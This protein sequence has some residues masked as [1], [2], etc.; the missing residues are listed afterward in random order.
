MKYHK[1]LREKVKDMDSLY[2]LE[3]RWPMK[4]YN[5]IQLERTLDEAYYPGLSEEVLK[6]LNTD[7]VVM[8]ALSIKSDNQKSDSEIPILT[9]PQ[10]WLWRLDHV[11]VSAYASA[12]QLGQ[13]EFYNATESPVIPFADLHIGH[14]LAHHVKAFNCAY[15]DGP[16]HFEP[17]LNIFETAMMQ[18]QSEL[19]TYMKVHGT[20]LDI[21]KEADFI[22]NI[23]DIR[24]EI[25]M[26]QDVLNQQGKVLYDLLEDPTLEPRNEAKDWAPVHTAMQLISDYRERTR[27]IDEDAQ[28]ID[29]V[30]QNKLN[31]KRTAASIEDAHQSVA[32]ARQ[33]KL[34]SIVVLG[35][36][37]IT[38]IF[39]PISFLAA[40]LALDIDT[41]D[42]IKY[43]PVSTD[44]ANSIDS[45]ASA[46][47]SGK[48]MAGLF[49]KSL[50]SNN[51]LITSCV[52]ALTL[53]SWNRN[54]HH[55]PDLRPDRWHWL[56]IAT[57][58]R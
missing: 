15:E 53:C 11:V 3:P 14:I 21:D 16:V 48:K 52:R 10:L 55:H 56:P 13:G 22:H 9:V 54:P 18:V 36:A 26:I 58:S 32:E 47:F 34:L 25:V 4:E 43:T 20:R 51:T 29:Q 30:I 42:G 31:L 17:V 49:G 33:S 44:T 24:S 6:D 28:R 35:F 57:I 12:E 19:N 50:F 37:I 1:E 45:Q 7:Q 38:I 5:H 27:K 46:V 8:R 39:T 23:S 2:S 40:L 41:F